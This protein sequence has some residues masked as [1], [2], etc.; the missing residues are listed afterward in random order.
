MDSPTSPSQPQTIPVERRVFW[1]KALLAGLAAGQWLLAAALTVFFPPSWD[2]LFGQPVGPLAAGAMLL[3]GALSA[4]AG[5]VWLIVPDEALRRAYQAVERISH[6]PLWMGLPL[7]LAALAALAGQF[8]Y[9]REWFGYAI[10]AIQLGGAALFCYWLA[11]AAWEPRPRAL[12][13]SAIV[14]LALGLIIRLGF[15]FADFIWTDEGFHLSATAGM[16]QGKTIAPETMRFPDDILIGPWR[17]YLFGVYGPWARLFGLGL[18][19]QR[20]L[21]YVVG[22]IALALIFGTVRRWY[23]Q[24]TAWVTTGLIALSFLFLQSTRARC[25]TIPLAAIALTAYALTRAEE[26]TTP[27][28]HALVGLLAALSLEGHFVNVIFFPVWGGFYAADYLKRA[29]KARKL[30]VGAPLWY[31][32]IGFLPGVAAY[33]TVHV[34]LLPHPEAWLANT[35]GVA[36]EGS[37]LAGR[38]GVYVE[39]WRIYAGFAPLDLVLIAAALI[40][41]LIRRAAPDR[42]WLLLF[43]LSQVGYLAAAPQAEISHTI[44]G[45]PFFFGAAGALI[46]YGLGQ[47]ERPGRPVARIVLYGIALALIIHGVGTARLRDLVRRS[48]ASTNQPTVSA[49][50]ARIP[51]GANLIAPPSM[52]PYL[53]E[54]HFLHPYYWDVIRGPALAGEAVL[55]YWQ[56]ILLETWPAAQIKRPSQFRELPIFASY[57]DALDAEEVVDGLWVIDQDGLVIDAPY[58]TLD[59]SAALQ[60]VAHRGPEVDAGGDS[61]TVQTVWVT[62]GALSGDYALRAML[63][64]GEGTMVAQS[65]AAMTGTQGEPTGEW[66]PYDFQG[67]QA[68]IPL[69]GDLAG[70]Y[71][72]RLAVADPDDGRSPAACGA[73]CVVEVGMVSVG[74]Q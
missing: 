50:Q 65:E 23:G 5:A 42:R 33:L 21:A 57:I 58:T 54:Y 31:F 2:S 63:I 9:G 8:L 22:L 7:G 40:A 59:P 48:W 70:E 30:I 74:E 24:S 4:L 6:S 32:L 10:M 34:L 66:T 43:G 61:L 60:M 68:A 11:P 53:V 46:T 1:L 3:A 18:T 52:I 67:V 25:D 72:L 17:G 45:L 64:D 16:L 14:L 55:P 39:R 51:P 19:Q 35:Q 41:A 26:K 36:G 12:V 71:T 20:L 38:L 28:P 49:I 47:E 37:S 27:W 15:V 13:I 73:G 56:N 62:R 44:Y 69:T 29:I